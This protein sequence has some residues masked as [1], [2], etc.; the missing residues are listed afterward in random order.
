MPFWQLNT[1]DA[2]PTVAD[3]TALKALDTTKYQSVLLTESG[4]A[5]TFV[6]TSGNYSARVTADTLEGIYIKATDTASSAGA[7]VRVYSGPAN[8]KWFGAM[9]D[10][11]AADLTSLQA[12]T[13]LCDDVYIPDGTYKISGPWL[14]DDNATLI[15]QSRSALIKSS[16]MSSSSAILRARGTSSTRNFYITI[17]SGMLQGP[18]SSGVV[19]I[20]FLS[21]SYGL[22]EGTFISQCGEGIKIGGSGSLGAFYNRYT[23]GI[24]TDVTVGVRCGT[25]GNENVFRGLR[26]GSCVVGTDDDDNTCNTY[27]E[28]AIEVFSSTGHRVC[29]TGA[30]SQRIRYI[31][32]RLENVGGVGIGIDV[33]AAAQGTVVSGEFYTG[34]ATGVQDGGTGTDRVASY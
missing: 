10:N 26:I 34:V 17:K 30:A 15:F 2:N 24:L 28:V 18:V 12:A 7:W 13:D 1:V 31:N 25:L 23:D 9:G 5:G 19:G 6:F 14:L 21:T 11:S 33:K 3:R 8:V 22:V 32:S 27:D 20:D 16:E 4:R 29:N